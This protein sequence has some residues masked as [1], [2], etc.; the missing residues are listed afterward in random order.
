MAVEYA[1]CALCPY[2]WS[3]RFCRNGK[4]KAPKNCP[5]LRHRELAETALQTVK[6][7]P[8]LLEFSCQASA[9]ETAGY[10]GREQGY[11]H[12][13]PIK[14]RLLEVAEF[15]A[16]MGYKRLGLAFCGGLR[17]E[18]LAVHRFLEDKGFE[19]A[20]MMC[21]SGA[22]PKS[23]LGI[24]RNGQVDPTSESETMCNPVFQAMTA[25]ESGV[26]FNILLGLCVGHDSL[27]IQHAKAPV[28]VLA[29]KDRVLGHNPLAAVY[30]LDQY[31]RYLKNEPLG[32]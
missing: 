10:G 14:P 17:N 12:I 6:N 30:Q 28:T 19:V 16:R 27:F 5:S 1:Q 18:G 9:Q 7:D 22:V 21:K 32:E 26:E 8:A 31:Y 29:V 15:S 23:E 25:N 3:E 20:S 4:G 2:D 24:D 13:R 11:A